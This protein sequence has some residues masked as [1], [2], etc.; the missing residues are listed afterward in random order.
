MQLPTWSRNLLERR[1]RKRERSARREMFAPVRLS[2][3][4]LE[5]RRVLDV[6]AAFMTGTGVLE[7][8]VTDAS[9]IATL[10]DSGGN[11]SIRDSTNA[12]VDIISGGAPTTVAWS[13]VKEIVV[14]GDAATDQRVV[15]DTQLT[16]VGRLEVGGEIEST[17]LTDSVN[18]GASI[19]LGSDVILEND[20]TLVGTS[21]TFGGSLDSQPNAIQNLIINAGNG[22]IAFNGDIGANVHLGT[23]DIQR[24]DGGVTF[25]DSSA[26]REVN[27][28]R[29]I[30]IGSTDAIGGTGIVFD[31]GTS[32]TEI[33]TSGDAVTIN[34]ATTL[35]S[36]LSI[37]TGSKGGD[38]IFTSASPI[39]SEAGE[40][41]DLAIDAGE[42]AVSFNQNIGEN[43][44][45]GRLIITRAAR[46]ATLG[47]ASP[48]AIVHA[49]DGIDI[50]VGTN[51]I[52]GS[53]IVLNGG[54]STLTLLT[55]G[56]NV[57]LNG[58]T[59]LASDV[60]F[61][62][63][64][65]AGNVTLTNDTPVDSIAG[66][67]ND[68]TFDVGAGSVF[69]NEDLGRIRP[70]G[71]LTVVSAGGGVVF[72]EATTE[73][74]GAGSTGP[75][76]VIKVDD[77]ID[78]GVGA[79]VIG[80]VGVVFRGTAVS[81]TT[82]TT[83]G[84]N[85]RI[86]GATTLGTNVTF[87]TGSGA[88]NLDFT[89]NAPVEGVSGMTSNLTAE[90]G[91]GALFFNADI[92]SG[93][94]ISGLTVGSAK[95]GVTFGATA[96]VNLVR[97]N[98]PIDIGVGMSV[99]EGTGITLNGGNNELLFATSNDNVRLNGAI[100]AQSDIAIDT[101]DGLGNIT[102]TSSTTI[103]SDD[104]PASATTIERN[105]VRL[106]A[107]DGAV[108]I[109]ANL[110]SQ[111]QLGAFAIERA[112]GGVVVGGADAN[113]ISGRGPVTEIATVGPINIG[114]AAPITGGI[115]LNGG[116]SILAINTS[117]AN[118]DFD[119]PIELQSNV[120]ISTGAGG[121]TLT[122]SSNATLDSQPGEANNFSTTL[123]IGN[124]IFGTSVGALNPLNE[125]RV[126]SAK[127]VTAQAEVHAA[128]IVQ[129]AG[130]GTT[131]FTGDVTTTDATLPGIDLTG[132]GFVF[133][134]P[135]TTT[136]NGSVSITHS[137]LLDINS[138]AD[139]RLDGS[140]TESGFGT[141]ELAGNIVTSGDV[142]HFGSP[143]TLTDGMLADVLLDTTAAANV[144]G[145]AIMFDRSV[146]AQNVG[147]ES[148]TL[149]AGTSGNIT[150][151]DAVG[152]VG[153]VGE[154]RI[155]E[156]NDVSLAGASTASNFV[157]ETG[158]GTTTF[159]GAIDANSSVA[160]AVDVN[161]VNISLAGAVTTAGDGRVELTATGVLD[162]G[163]A[164]DMNL[165]GSFTQDGGGAVRT[166]ADI[167]TSNNDIT[168]TDEVVVRES[169]RF[170]TGTGVGTVSFANTLD[171]TNDCQE[172]ITLALGT[173]DAVFQ[174]AVGNL[175]GLGDLLVENAKDIRFESS[176]V[177]SS[178]TQDAGSGETRFDGPVTIKTA[179]GVDLTTASV[180]IDSMLNTSAA[181]GPISITASND[182]RVNG[183]VSTGIASVKLTA[184][185]EV[186]FGRNASITTTGADVTILADAD[187]SMNGFG[188]AVLM[189]DGAVISTGS[190][191][192]DIG[193]DENIQ[194]GR[195]V[196]STLVRLTST[197]GGIVDGGDVGGADIVADQLA[198]RSRTGVGTA[199][200]IDTTVNTIAAENKRDGGVRVENTN[201]GTL[202]VGTVDGLSGIKN[203]PIGAPE[204]LE[205]EVELIHVG[206]IDVK[207]A[208]LNDGGS[209]TIVRAELAGDLTI[210]A[211]IQNQGG[212]GWIFLFSGEDLII[213]DS[214]P[215]PQAE[216]SVE[217]EGAIRGEAIGDVIIDNSDTEYVIV[218]THSERFPVMG[219]PP[220]LSAKFQDPTRYPPVTDTAFYQELEAELQAIRNSVSGQATNFAPLF[221][222]EPV[223]QGGSDV[224]SSGRGI[225][226]VTIGNGVHLE[227]N[228]HFTI[229]W[230]DGT[231]ES[232][233]VP[234][235]P[236][237]SLAFLTAM[238]GNTNIT[239]DLT[240]TARIDSGVG[241]EPGVYYVHHKYLSPPD[242]NDPSKPTP[243][244]ATLRYDAREEG[245]QALDLTRPSD[246]STI[247]N[248]IRFFRNGTESVQ[249]SQADELTNPGEG[250]T[251]FIK[252][253]E[254]VIVPVESRQTTTIIVAATTNTVTITTGSTSDFVVASFEAEVFEDYRLFMRVVDDVAA[255]AQRALPV[256]SSS[257]AGEG[258]E[259][260]PL[261]L[262]LLNDPLS[263]FRERKF[264]NG[265][266]RV[267]LEELRTGRVRL[268]LDVHIY[269]GRVVPEN[270]RDGAAERQPGSDDSSQLQS[271]HDSSIVTAAGE[272]SDSQQSTDQAANKGG[273]RG[274]NLEE[275]QTPLGRS[276]LL[277][278]VAA[279][280]L[281]WRDRVRKALQ[282]ESRAISRTSLRL[283]RHR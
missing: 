150:F 34:G 212:N 95:A 88:G 116:G 22:S 255:R 15:F 193:A 251:T 158:H 169:V 273:E 276:D 182:I 217:N 12:S 283:R 185:D 166:S 195:L 259:E 250:T 62:T 102:L 267:Y 19:L 78:L 170:D 231:I 194:L 24:A 181:S 79:N 18:A 99:I 118:V 234:G 23:L 5:E 126:V 4:K 246:G 220:T 187:G 191:V 86:N 138:A 184:D 121:G 132:T 94:P 63:G 249:A 16:L 198:L 49:A 151:G 72:G 202:T 81:G 33:T 69:V 258:E 159:S 58:S 100:H 125:L 173:G 53:G 206:A 208:I 71:S 77:A 161:A 139:M 9:E 226:K 30:T 140:F 242:P 110:G 6:S 192:I 64:A 155:V 59:T 269:E 183:V 232:Y 20:V 37:N 146:N 262:E 124:A 174:A 245:E 264:P 241:G 113:V 162:I 160:K 111:Q 89:S 196:T 205:G 27:T 107:G 172:D 153:R 274:V 134:G 42:G 247:F 101:G 164:A 266:Y 56:A 171:G 90:L 282:S 215:E 207:A 230:G 2:L 213:N 85:I 233:S 211:P 83:T 216:I 131:S 21:V 128:R 103:D 236:Q 39:D 275:T 36:T 122:L 51:A 133:N 168:F 147:G 178:I 92:G 244:F 135:V 279:A 179:T 38:V 65:G 41:N 254:S 237:A 156:A 261:P 112:S 52:A 115:V 167:T 280:T 104:G 228:W 84:D 189:A 70:L 96:P 108:S 87:N 114:S 44:A 277:L 272:G 175:V 47:D 163:A 14:R 225:V 75:V 105:S 281:P 260:F 176:L 209:H 106:D 60:M 43:E 222:I 50:G 28:E 224:D 197:S 143:V 190:G 68:L 243:I 265:H 54:A 32:G 141:V 109:N 256:G 117:A 45:L 29:P 25:G 270:F 165:S 229:D 186:L 271:D 223:D 278:P 74:P 98:H 93:T 144:A 268:I 201:G 55:D 238:G 188:G 180:T 13:D 129:Q 219:T 123:G 10:Q 1:R 154:L 240:N 257:T 199:N 76:Q 130:S 26:V 17:V 203:G 67:F 66:K 8:D 214:L 35:Q 177:A 48:V 73:V 248:G 235:N 127:D 204:K 7:L 97:T 263:I 157:Q 239:P 31:G 149:N 137:G 221:E 145:A 218:R 91:D 252:V 253:I 148:L 152:G 120:S 3:R 119:G 80:G 11:V 200:P 142:I 82:I 227:T 46:G 61:A 136:G 40:T 210:D 57:R